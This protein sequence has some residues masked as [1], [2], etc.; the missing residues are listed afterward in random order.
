MMMN[1]ITSLDGHGKSSGDMNKAMERMSIVFKGRLSPDQLEAIKQDIQSTVM[2]PMAGDMLSNAGEGGDTMMAHMS[3]DMMGMAQ[4]MGVLPD[5]NVNP[6]TGLPAFS[7]TG[8]GASGADET[9]GVNASSEASNDPDR[10]MVDEQEGYGD[11]GRER[12]SE[13]GTSSNPNEDRA[14]SMTGIQSVAAVDG[15]N[16]TY[17]DATKDL[18]KHD[19]NKAGTFGVLNSLPGMKALAEAKDKPGF[20][21]SVVDARLSHDPSE[22]QLDVNN[23]LDRG[24]RDKNP[25]IASLT[26]GLASIAGFISPALAAVNMATNINDTMAGY[27]LNSLM[28]TTTQS[29]PA[30]LTELEENLGVNVTQAAKDESDIQGSRD[31]DIAGGGEVDFMNFEP[32]V[33]ETEPE[34]DPDL[35][36]DAERAALLGMGYS[37]ADATTIIENFGSLDTFKQRFEGRFGTEPTPG[38]IANPSAREFIQVPRGRPV[39]IGSIMT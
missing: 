31:M 21:D 15:Y 9:G 16:K 27:G 13:T 30:G 37:P 22:A 29:R 32:D 5:G 4:E 38:S 39:G 6:M 25:G 19:L 8:G 35:G 18:S 1:G 26:G 17:N 34:P 20:L 36:V 10:D 3:P 2:T 23:A 33:P 7:A 28:G 11:P 14:R 12:S 24:F